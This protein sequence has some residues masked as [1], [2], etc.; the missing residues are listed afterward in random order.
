MSDIKKILETLRINQDIARSFFEI[1]SS[2]LSILNFKDLFERLLT[3]IKEKL[4]IPY[5]W[6]SIIEKSEVFNLTEK[7]TSS[8]TLRERLNFIDRNTFTNLTENKSKPVL[9]NNDL[10]SFYKLMP[11]KHKYLI[12][13]LSIA[14]LTVDGEI[15]GSL[16]QAD[17]SEQRF[18][19]DMDTSLLEQLAVKISI[20]LSN[21]IA[22]E[23]LKLLAFRDPLTGLLNRR[24][25][26]DALKREFRR[27]KRYI[28]PLSLI[29]LDLDDLKIV[30]DRYGHN[31]GDD[32]LKYVAT[33]L[34]DMS[35]ESDVV[36]RVGGDEFVIILPGTIAEEAYNFTSRLQ[37]FFQKNP[38]DT[39]ETS[40]HASISSGIAS[41][42]DK[43][44]RNAES[45]LKK[46]D[47]MLYH[48]KKLKWEHYSDNSA[49][50]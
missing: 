31:I 36:A 5:V 41:T 27:A 24:V 6:I 19:P 22:H 46:A 43:T 2:I 47:I 3:E 13:S 10:K 39:Q 7:L 9:I 29:Y 35:R 40:I 8:E 4:E 49:I 48:A 50:K 32:L 37:N 23:K 34:E 12:R 21:V 25:M 20:C 33:H 44:I 1:E 26:D 30:N 15:I 28:T 38:L 18:Q 17:H 42:E 16:N 14:P 11:Q 45:L